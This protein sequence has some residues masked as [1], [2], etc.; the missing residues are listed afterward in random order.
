MMLYS[1]SQ[2]W[3]SNFIPKNFPSKLRESGGES[4]REKF[5]AFLYVLNQFF[6]LGV[7]FHFTSDSTFLLFSSSTLQSKIAFRSVVFFLSF[8]LLSTLRNLF[9]LIFRRESFLDL[10]FTGKKTNEWKEENFPNKNFPCCCLELF[11]IT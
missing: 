9:S 5:L 1:L 3:K 11:F 10:F 6:S 7:V 2:R 4:R 8:R